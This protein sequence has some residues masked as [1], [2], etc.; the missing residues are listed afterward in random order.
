MVGWL[1]E[2]REA[3]LLIEP[4]C[5]SRMGEAS[6]VANGD[7]E[8]RTAEKDAERLTNTHYMVDNTVTE[9]K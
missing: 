4:S 7:D 6:H 1:E 2:K 9:N 5:S 8:D 3:T